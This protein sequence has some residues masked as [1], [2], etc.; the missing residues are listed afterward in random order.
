MIPRCECGRALRGAWSPDQCRLC[1]LALNDERYMAAWGISAPPR[2]S[3]TPRWGLG[4]VIK[5]ALSSINVTPEAVERLLGVPCGCSERAEKMD[6]LTQL[7][8]RVAKGKVEG[9]RKF[10]ASIFGK[11]EEDL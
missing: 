3:P 2:S 5:D 11:K 4:T 10:L 9:A 7:A 6:Q 8:V 1:W